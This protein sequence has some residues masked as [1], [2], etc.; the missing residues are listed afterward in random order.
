[1][2]RLPGEIRLK[3]YRLLHKHTGRIADQGSYFNEKTPCEAERAYQDDTSLSSQ[4]L[5]TCQQVHDEAAAVLYDENEVDLRCESDTSGSWIPY[6]GLW[7]SVLDTEMLMPNALHSLPDLDYDILKHAEDVPS[8]W[9]MGDSRFVQVLQPRHNG[10]IAQGKSFT[11]TY[12]TLRRF[13]KMYLSISASRAE[14]VVVACRLLRDLLFHKNVTIDIPYAGICDPRV[15]G[16]RFL[17]CCGIRFSSST[18]LCSQCIR[19]LGASI[20]SWE[21]PK[22][23]VKKW[24]RFLNLAHSLE[25]KEGNEDY[26]FAGVFREEILDLET[27]AFSY[28]IMVYEALE[29]RLMRKMTEWKDEWTEGLI[30]MARE[31]QAA[32]E[33]MIEEHT[34]GV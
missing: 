9:P 31:R 22:D 34:S 5:R 29:K 26:E 33:K 27:A 32:M 15:F 25:L 30:A 8:I 3:I 18:K 10:Q 17:R 2:L 20:T 21:P 11:Q 4:F 28:D 14:E 13:K 24:R 12:P 23:T 16:C 7:C 6:D 1:M 19:T